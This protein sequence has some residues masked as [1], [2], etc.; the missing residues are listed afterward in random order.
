[1]T[2]P[3]ATFTN[4]PGNQH[5]TPAR[6]LSPSSEAEVQA[7]VRAAVAASE[8]VRVVATGHS[9]TPVHLTDGTL[10][11]LDNLRGLLG[12]DAASRRV[13]A[14]PGTTV[15]DFGDPLW[16]LAQCELPP[17]LAGR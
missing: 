17:R 7:A 5:C 14:L 12:I 8:G 4:W 1:M 9:F 11:D 2:A 16:R 10:L 6:R 15:G 3:R 13:R